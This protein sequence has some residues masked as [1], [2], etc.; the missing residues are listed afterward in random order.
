MH[1]FNGDE[2]WQQSGLNVDANNY[3]ISLSSCLVLHFSI[4][5]AA[6]P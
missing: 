3:N 2:L 5:L 6:V 4:G 1:S